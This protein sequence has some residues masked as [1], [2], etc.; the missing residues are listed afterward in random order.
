[1]A[2]QELVLVNDIELN[3][4][5]QCESEPDIASSKFEIYILIIF[6]LVT[7]VIYGFHLAYTIKFL[8]KTKRITEVGSS[9]K[10]Q[11]IIGNLAS[12]IVLIIHAL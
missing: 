4:E 7:A 3:Q 8:I 11:I 5:A 2:E 12:A 1:M 6:F 9:T 10:I